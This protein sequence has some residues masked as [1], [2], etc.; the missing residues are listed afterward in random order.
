MPPPVRRKATRAKKTN[1]PGGASPSGK[2]ELKIGGPLAQ[3]AQATANGQRSE[4]PAAKALALAEKILTAKEMEVL[5]LAYGEENPWAGVGARLEI[6][7]EEALAKGLDALVKCG[8]T[9]P[10]TSDQSQV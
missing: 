9:L 4:V 10:Q 6:T 1:A 5:R 7:K 2:P 8:A 3:W